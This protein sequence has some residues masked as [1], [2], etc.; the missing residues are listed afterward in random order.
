[1]VCKY[2]VDLFK[3]SEYRL[4][5]RLGLDGVDGVGTWFDTHISPPLQAVQVF[6]IAVGFATWNQI[7]QCQ[8]F[9]FLC[10]N[11]DYDW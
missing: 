6:C 2:F 10:H 3:G 5:P 7:F 11:I 9:S 1:M 8:L 4:F